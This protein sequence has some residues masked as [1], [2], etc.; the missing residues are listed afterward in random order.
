M[1]WAEFATARQL[2]AE[3]R[4]GR[5]LREVQAQEDAKFTA[6]KKAIERTEKRGIR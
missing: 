3:E 6:A 2:I 4:V 5:L 1:T